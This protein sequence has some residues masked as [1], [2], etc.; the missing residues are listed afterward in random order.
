MTSYGVGCGN[1]RFP[2]VYFRTAKFAKWIYNNIRNRVE[3]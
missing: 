3:G 2:G 1:E